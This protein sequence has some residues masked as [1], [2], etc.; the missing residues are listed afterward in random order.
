VVTVKIDFKVMPFLHTIPKS[1]IRSIGDHLGNA[2]NFY[3]LLE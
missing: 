3:C 2:A 1:K